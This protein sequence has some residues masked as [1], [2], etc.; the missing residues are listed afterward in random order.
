MR[1]PILCIIFFLAFSCATNTTENRPNDSKSVSEVLT[2]EE[3]Q[4]VNWPWPDKFLV[5][6]DLVLKGHMD[7]TCEYTFL[8]ERNDNHYTISG[9]DKL[10][11]LPQ[12]R[13]SKI[14]EA[15]FRKFTCL[16]PRMTVDVPNF[17][18]V[19]IE[20]LESAKNI[21]ETIEYF[22]AEQDASSGEKFAA[23]TMYRIK[24]N[25]IMLWWLLLPGPEMLI[26][27]PVEGVETESGGGRTC[28]RFATEKEEIQDEVALGEFNSKASRKGQ[29]PVDQLIH[30]TES[31]YCYSRELHLHL[32]GSRAQ[33]VNGV[34]LDDT[35][36]TF[37]VHD[38]EVIH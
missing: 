36:W 12:T 5:R 25:S 24:T 15:A 16:I 1:F 37:V 35:V 21:V 13:D 14:F 33:F 11:E 2:Q 19:N 28:V 3:R 20:P 7:Q 23:L 6:G 4:K 38:I 27:N 26:S 29:E 31:E 32:S 30:R 9:G 22:F 34:L 8:F 17:M 10:S 18:I